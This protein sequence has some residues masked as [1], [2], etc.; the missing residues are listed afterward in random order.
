MK[1][2]ATFLK[3][4]ISCVGLL[5][6]SVQ[7]FAYVTEEENHDAIKQ[8]V[9]AFIEKNIQTNSGER[10]NVDVG[11]IDGRLSLARCTIPLEPFTG[12]SNNNA[13]MIV[14]VRCEGVQPWKIYVPV[15][16]A[17][18]KKVVVA[19]NPLNKGI[20]LTAEDLRLTE[21]NTANLNS[22]F[23]TEKDAL[24]GKVLTRSVSAG[25]PLTNAYL[26]NPVLIQRGQMVTLLVKKGELEVTSHGIALNKGR[27]GDVI[28]V[29]NT[30]SKRVI[31][32]TVMTGQMVEVYVS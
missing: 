32:G 1:V 5:T 21:Q 29:K 20:P 15:R 28:A 11:Y 22:G 12:N 14:G 24:I 27:V 2:F 23:Y 30:S 26:E 25:M 16:V 3:Y 31:E 18:Y 7:T 6:L 13:N 4:F 19:S 17:I 9:A 8:V 10:V